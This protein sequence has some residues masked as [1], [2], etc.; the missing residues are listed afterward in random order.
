MHGFIPDRVRCSQPHPVV[1]V[2]HHRPSRTA[3]AGGFELAERSFFQRDD[4]LRGQL[5]P[6]LAKQRTRRA[7]LRLPA[8]R[9][10]RTSVA[11]EKHVASGM[12]RI[13]HQENR[14]V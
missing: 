10:E 3:V 1:E 11:I 12:A 7:P 5:A 13:A 8:L 4:F 14:L 6:A 2:E 9:A